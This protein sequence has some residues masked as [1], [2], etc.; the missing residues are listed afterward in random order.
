MSESKEDIRMDALKLIA[1]E[2]VKE[3]VPEFS[4]GDTVRVD[5]DRVRI[6]VQRQFF[7]IA[8][9]EQVFVGFGDLQI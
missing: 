4:I 7:G 2:S 3:T 9:R 6:A 8:H 1:A 5:V